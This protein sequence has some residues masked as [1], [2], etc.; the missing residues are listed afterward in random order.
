MTA[1]G[2]AKPDFTAA[3][4]RAIDYDNAKRILP[5]LKTI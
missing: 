2:L 1:Q 5:K 3:E 4:A